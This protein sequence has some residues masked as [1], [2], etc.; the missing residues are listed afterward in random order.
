M[1]VKS[2]L[3]ARQFPEQEQQEHRST[4]KY[5]YYI[6]AVSRDVAQVSAILNSGDYPLF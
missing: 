6:Q 4:N 3:F 2:Y 5:A 1:N